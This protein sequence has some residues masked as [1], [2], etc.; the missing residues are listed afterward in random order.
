[1]ESKIMILLRVYGCV[2]NNNG[3]WIGWLDLL[4]ASFAITRNHNQLQEL[5]INL[6]P[7]P[8][9]MTAYNSLNSDWTASTELKVKVVLRPTVSGPVCL[10]VKHPSGAYDQIFFLSDSC[11]FVDVGRPPDEMTGLSFTMYN[12]Q[13]IYILHLI[14]WMYIQYIQGL[15]QCRLNTADHA[16]SL[17]ASAYEF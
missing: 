12:V 16:L 1:M 10:G 3:F 15:C 14:T 6:Q 13:Y 4:T 9:S 7:S 2:T 11:R 5:T 17:V 8:S